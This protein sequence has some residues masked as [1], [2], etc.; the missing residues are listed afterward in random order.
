MTLRLVY[1][2]SATIL[3]AVYVTTSAYAEDIKRVKIENRTTAI[4]E[5]KQDSIKLNV[6][7]CD[8]SYTC[9]ETF[10]CEGLAPDKR[11]RIV[12]NGATPTASVTPGRGY[13][14]EIG[15]GLQYKDTTQRDWKTSPA[16]A[17]PVGH[18]NSDRPTWGITIEP[19]MGSPS[20]K[21]L[22]VRLYRDSCKVGANH[23]ECLTL[24][25]SSTQFKVEQY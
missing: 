1:V 18:H 13:Y 4:C 9:S 14:F 10:T 6:P 2:T 11:V 5:F 12:S 24:S 19:D 15:G 8:G 7:K 22:D 3:S 23:Q 16:S 25:V 21:S 20:P 17:V